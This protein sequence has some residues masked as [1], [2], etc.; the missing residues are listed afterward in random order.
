MVLRPVRANSWNEPTLLQEAGEKLWGILPA[1][2]LHFE[3]VSRDNL[4]RS[5]PST[6]L[7]VF[8]E[9]AAALDTLDQMLARLI[10]AAA[11]HLARA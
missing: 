8:P 10:S 4:E 5:H 1:T 3:P 7:S 11:P 2:R 6:M 9:G